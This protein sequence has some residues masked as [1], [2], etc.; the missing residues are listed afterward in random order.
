GRE[1]GRIVHID[2]E[3]SK[4]RSNDGDKIIIII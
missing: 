3:V 2:V 1:G 4:Y